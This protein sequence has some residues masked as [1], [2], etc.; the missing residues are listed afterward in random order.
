MASVGVCRNLVKKALFNGQLKAHHLVAARQGSGTPAP[1]NYLWRPD[2]KF[3]NEPRISLF[4][5]DLKI[6]DL[7][8]YFFSL[9]K[10]PVTKEDKAK[11]ARKYGMIEEDYEP[12]GDTHYSTYGWMDYGDYPKL[13]NKGKNLRPQRL[14]PSSIECLRHLDCLLFKV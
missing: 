1:W 11:A 2:R 6:F 4:S 9:V 8:N 12:L 13:E 5:L 10:L 7:I 14:L 3:S